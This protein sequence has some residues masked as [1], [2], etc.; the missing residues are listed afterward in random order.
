MTPTPRRSFGSVIWSVA[1]ALA[2]GLGAGGGWLTDERTHTAWAVPAAAPAAAPDNSIALLPFLTELSSP[3]LITHAGDGSGRLFVVEQTGRIRVVVNGAVLPTAFLD[4]R[5][6]VQAGGEQG[7]LG[8]AFHPNYASNG[9]FFVYYTAKPPPGSTCPS[10]FNP[11]A[12]CGDN[13]VA[14]YQVSGNPEVANPTPVRTLFALRDHFSNHNGGMLGFNPRDAAGYLYVGTGDEGSGGDPLENAQNLGVLYGKIL[15]LDVDTI[16]GGQQYGIP[17]TNPFVGQGGA[18]PEIWAYGVRNPWRWSFDRLTGDMFIGDVGQ[19]QWEEID[20]LPNGVGGRN[21]GWDDREG[22]HC[23]EPSSG[24]ATAGRT[25][26]ILEYDHA[27]GCSVTGGY[28]YRG[29]ANPALQGQY[30][31]ADYCAGRIWRASQSG[32]T[33]TAVE[34]LDTTH[35]ISGFGEDAAGELYVVTLGGSIFRLAQT[36]TNCSPRP[37]VSLQSVRTGPGTYDVTV[38]AN[39]SA[40][41]SGNLLSSIAFHRIVNA[42]VTIGSQANQRSPFTATLPGTSST[43]RFTVQRV[44]AGQAMHVD[45]RATDRC[46]VWSTFFGAGTSTN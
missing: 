19:G 30:F 23:F 6:I 7:L 18:R 29:S 46:G 25:D 40:G 8:L 12:N 27:L 1:L 21:F 3:V 35:N 43:A 10:S 11:A 36:A 41:L 22:A 31:Y 26:P 33:W 45:V 5:S 24:C 16:P 2:V 9:R 44:Q 38:T 37:H 20:F 17:P 39:D 4:L 14:E 15:R 32:Q 13:T 28:R 42:S 34:A